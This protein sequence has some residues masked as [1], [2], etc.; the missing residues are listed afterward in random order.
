MNRWI[1][2]RIISIIFQ[3]KVSPMR[4]I[5]TESEIDNETM[6]IGN[7]VVYKLDEKSEHNSQ[8]NKTVPNCE[9]RPIFDA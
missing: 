7:H 6:I 5:K 1:Y 8:S 3:T 2:S 9:L 4:R